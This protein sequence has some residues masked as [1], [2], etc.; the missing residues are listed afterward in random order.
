VN[1]LTPPELLSVLRVAK[2]K[3]A[4]DHLLILL[5]YRHGLRAS[6]VTNLRTTDLIDGSISI[7]RL[8][9]SKTTLQPLESHR[10]EP[11]L[12]E[13]K[14]LS[15]WMRIR[16]TQSGDA[17]LTSAKGGCLTGK[18]FNFIFHKYAAL[19]GLPK[20]KSNPHILKHTIC[21]HLVRAGLSL[22]YVQQRVGHSAISSTQ[23]YV[24]L[25]DREVAEKTHDA[26]MNIF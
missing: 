21:N 20:E 10:G 9:G 26:L 18:S 12:N 17:L 19:A 16:P 5:A 2:E 25:N 23:R 7:K 8:K 22:S 14:A 13:V 3:S 24:S 15:D 6:E 1:F 4:R 11:L